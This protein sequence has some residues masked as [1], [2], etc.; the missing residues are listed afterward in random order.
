[1]GLQLPDKDMAHPHIVAHS[2]QHGGVHA[3]VHGRQGRPT[4]RDGMLELHGK[5]GGVATGSA[6]AHREH[7]ALAQVHLGHGMSHIHES[8]GVGLE[9]PLLDLLRVLGLMAHGLQQSR[10]FVGRVF[11]RSVQK[12]IEGLQGIRSLA[13]AWALE[14]KPPA[15]PVPAPGWRRLQ[16]PRSRGLAD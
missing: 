15:S 5:V 2:G 14:V 11:L 1:M 7:A 16:S 13:H 9:K 12:R 4:C 3:E 8:M 6:V 10:V